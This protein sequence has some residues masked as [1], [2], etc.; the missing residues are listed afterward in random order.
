MLLPF[1]KLLEN[2]EAG[3]QYNIIFWRKGRNSSLEQGHLLELTEYPRN[4][5]HLRQ[6]HQCKFQSL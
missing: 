2:M 4:L 5:A 1:V 3:S 6:T